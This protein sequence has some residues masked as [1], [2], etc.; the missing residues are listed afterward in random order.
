MTMVFVNHERG[1]A[2]EAAEKILFMA[3]RE[4]IEQGTPDDIFNHPKDSRIQECI[5]RIL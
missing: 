2:R 5:A 3:D 1:F 4:I